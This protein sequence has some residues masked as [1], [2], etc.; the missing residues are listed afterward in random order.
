MVETD[1]ME[2]DRYV[3]RLTC[4]HEAL[5]VVEPSE[6]ATPVGDGYVCRECNRTQTVVE[7]F[8]VDP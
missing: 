1:H 8:R 5:E 7:S 6:T 4:G 3:V 2:A